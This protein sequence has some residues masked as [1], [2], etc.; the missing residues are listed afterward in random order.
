MSSSITGVLERPSVSRLWQGPFVESK[1]A[2]LRRNNDFSPGRPRPRCGLRTRHERADVPKG[3][4]I[5]GSTS[6]RQYVDPRRAASTAS[7]LAGLDDRSEPLA[8]EESAYLDF[9]LAE[10][11]VPPPRHSHCPGDPRRS[12][13]ASFGRRAR[14]R[15]RSRT[16]RQRAN[17]ATSR[18][19]GPRQVREAAGGVEGPLLSEAF[20]PVCLR[21]VPGSRSRAGVLEDGLLQGAPTV[22]TSTLRNPPRV[23]IAVAE[24]T[25]R[26]RCSPS[27]CAGS[28][29]SWTYHAG[30]P[31]RSGDRGR[32][33]SGDRTLAPNSE[34]AA[35]KDPRPGGG[36]P[37]AQLRAPGGADGG[38]RSR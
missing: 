17:P 18:S 16:A 33:Q 26:R 20:E 32:R 12:V 27:F 37:V 29:R 31:P 13:D 28:A 14:S 15:H 3:S 38:A 5:W 6:V 25:T 8:L 10:Q 36:G 19:V 24:S 23:S 35:A 9:I 30:G 21:A 2:P 22:S 1:L 34:A 4:T 7:R 11:P